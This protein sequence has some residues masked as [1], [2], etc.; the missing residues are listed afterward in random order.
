LEKFGEPSPAEAP[1]QRGDLVF[2]RGHVGLMTGPDRLLHANGFHMAVVEENFGGACRRI[3]AAG[4][5]T[6]TCVTRAA[7]AFR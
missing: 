1:L 2:W 4:G 3:E 7:R 5:G 6:V